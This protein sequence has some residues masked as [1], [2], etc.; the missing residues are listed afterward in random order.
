MFDFKFPKNLLFNSLIFVAGVLLALSFLNLQIPTDNIFFASLSNSINSIRS[1]SS[2][3][4][5][6][7][8]VD[9]SCPTCTTEETP[10]A[11]DETSSTTLVDENDNILVQDP[12]VPTSDSVMDRGQEGVDWEWVDPEDYSNDE[13]VP[14]EIKKPEEIKKKI[15]KKISKPLVA[16]MDIYLDLQYQID[17]QRERKFTPTDPINPFDDIVCELKVERSDGANERTFEAVLTSEIISRPGVSNSRANSQKGQMLLWQFNKGTL[18]YARSDDF[19]DYYDW[20]IKGWDNGNVPGIIS[21]DI[22]INNAWAIKDW[23]ND[24]YGQK[25]ETVESWGEVYDNLPLDNIKCQIKSEE[26]VLVESAPELVSRC[27]RLWGD[28]GKINQ[29]N[30]KGDADKPIGMKVGFNYSDS[31]S[32]SKQD[33]VKNSIEAY[34]KGFWGIDPFKSYKDNFAFYVNLSKVFILPAFNQEV[35]PIT[36]ADWAHLRDVLERENQR[37]SNSPYQICEKMDESIYYAKSTKPLGRLLGFSYWNKNIAIVFNPAGEKIQV[38][39]EVLMHEV[40]HSFDV[41]DEYIDSS[42]DLTQNCVRDTSTKQKKK[43]PCLEFKETYFPGYYDQGCFPGCGPSA[44]SNYRSTI[45]SLMRGGVAPVF[46][47]NKVS[48]TPILQK[49]LG[50]SRESAYKK[51]GTLNTFAANLC[52]NN[53]QCNTY[54]IKGETF[55]SRFNPK[56]GGNIIVDGCGVCSSSKDKNTGSTCVSSK[57]EDCSIYIENTGKDGFGKCVS[58]EIDNINGPFTCQIND[59]WECNAT[60]GCVAGEKCN[61]VSHICE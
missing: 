55:N 13:Y 48:C 27:V 52:T 23:L 26:E 28:V 58:P 51:C 44:T 56:L 61:L 8:V 40:A 31:L 57:N 16:S 35:S 4:E 37:G 54:Y 20:S 32:G 42:V 17:T 7:P 25:M 50:L 2:D 10:A 22:K 3:E 24:T 39:K 11:I 15:D 59:K 19:F 1:T 14:P 53:E 12:E 45:T 60:Y 30:E 36:Q 34:Q 18:N 29:N 41:G 5:P 21:R 49:I 33:M 46:E 9:E 38:S 6:V 47:Y 43:D